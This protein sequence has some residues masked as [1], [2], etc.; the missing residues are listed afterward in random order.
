MINLT[1]TDTTDEV[2]EVLEQDQVDQIKQRSVRGAA[3]YMVRTLLLQVV[4]LVSAGVL[5]A[6]L[7]AADFGIYGIVTQIIGLLTFFSDVGLGSALIQKKAEPTEAEYRVVFTIQQLLSLGIFSITLGLVGSHALLDKLGPAGEWVLLTL[8][9]SFPLTTLKTISSV[10][11]ERKLEFSKL[12]IPQIVEQLLYQGI[13]IVLAIQ[14][15]GVMAYAYAIVARTVAGVGVMW[16]IQPWSPGLS[17]NKNALRSMLGS[18]TKFQLNDFIA[19]IKDNLFYLL[20]GL[21][22][23]NQIYGYITFAKTFSMLPYQLTVQN[24]I[25]V[26]FPTY[27]RLQHHPELLRKAIEK[28]LFFIS[29][30]IFPML[31]GMVMLVGPLTELVPRF[32]K[33]Q[34][35]LMTF[36][37]FTLSI[38]WSAVSTPLTN[39]LNA[40]GQISTTLKLMVMWTVLT[41]VLTPLLVWWLGYD[42]VGL[43]AFLIGI[44]SLIPI[45]L[46]KK[47]VPVQVWSQVWRQ[48]LA[49]CVMGLLGWVGQSWWGLSWAHFIGGGVLLGMTYLLTLALVGWTKVQVEV[50]GLLVKNRIV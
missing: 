6:Y 47:V 13:L 45:Y 2:V 15:F 24:V 21:Y 38:G 46:V 26:T 7:N 16:L 30:L 29:L 31:I 20:L 39:T 14:G 50:Q 5:A 37:W 22:L 19:R 17:L 32:A 18:G 23:P 49:A 10:K 11:L 36:S 25:A 1:P 33:W 40:I 3:S 8:G 28:T 9:L 27:A 12:V 44:T 4:G 41:W 43:A 35:A 42:G 48:L 34:P